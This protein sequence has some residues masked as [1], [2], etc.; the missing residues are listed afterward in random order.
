[1]KKN[2]HVARSPVVLLSYQALRLA[3]YFLF[4]WTSL[5]SQRHEAVTSKE[6]S[7]C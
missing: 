3:S 1:M 7:Q 5:G 4:A 2:F 6:P